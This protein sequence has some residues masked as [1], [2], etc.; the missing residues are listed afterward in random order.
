MVVTYRKYLINLFLK[1]YMEMAA[2]VAQIHCANEIVN[3]CFSL[4]PPLDLSLSRKCIWRE[5]LVVVFPEHW[6]ESS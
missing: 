2:A 3:R 6:S 5:S 1:M 4:L